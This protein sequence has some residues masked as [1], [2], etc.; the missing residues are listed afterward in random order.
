MCGYV[1]ETSNIFDRIKNGLV[2]ITRP[3]LRLEFN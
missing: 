3:F 1:K 2:A